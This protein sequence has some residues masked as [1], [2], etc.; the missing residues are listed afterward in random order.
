MSEEFKSMSNVDGR[1]TPTAD[2]RVP[3]LD[4]GFLYGDSIYEVFRTYSGVP[5]FYQEHWERLE[6]SARLIQ[7][8]ITQGRDEIT[9]QIRDTVAATSAGKL[10]RDVYVRYVITRG[11]GPPPIPMRG[12]FVHTPRRLV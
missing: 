12:V 2:A 9:E 3:V 1:I 7:M 6:N 5:L 8:H 4:R 11:E 10:S